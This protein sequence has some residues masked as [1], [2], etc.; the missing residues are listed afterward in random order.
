MSSSFYTV[1]QWISVFCLVVVTSSCSSFNKAKNDA[2][3]TYKP[4][5]AY[6]LDSFN[7]VHPLEENLVILAFSGGGSRAAAL[8]YGVLQELRDTQF[9][10]EKGEAKSLLSD[11][12]IIS[13]VSGGSFTA[14]YYGVFGDQ[15]FTDF[16]DDFLRQSVEGALVA[17]MLNPAY[18]IKS[19]SSGFDRTELAIEYYDKNIFKRKTFADIPLDKRP[20]IVINATDLSLGARFS[21]D[22]DIFD[23]LCSDLSSYPI[24]RAVTASSAVP[25]VFPSVILKNRSGAC[26][27][28]GSQVRSA[29]NSMDRDSQTQT[30]Y[31]A[32]VDA[33]QD[34]EKI[35]YIH[36]VDGG[37]TDNLGLR[38]ISDHFEI[39]G[40]HTEEKSEQSVK[41]I[42]LILVNSAVK[43]TREMDLMSSSPSIS[44][45]LD[46][47]TTTL[48]ESRNSDT[49]GFFFDK[50]SSFEN[51]INALNSDIEF[52]LTEV[53]FESIPSQ[54]T[55]Q[56]FNK[57]PTSLELEDDQIDLL[58]ETGR[59]LLR[60]DP[61][62]NR[63]KQSIGVIHEP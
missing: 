13:A 26:D 14:A 35:K 47:F 49:K 57:L 52:F 27:L 12:D 29:A 53:S 6:R 45:T 8:S 19:L 18:W 21:F 23:L 30:E 63:F 3:T 39:F 46:A 56:L 38:S 20:Y 43:P 24:A 28:S 61:N 32:M 11:V 50:A 40:L 55:R 2:I 51:T 16:E 54:K 62:F 59:K 7:R 31:L 48:I 9:V 42:V 17:N 41:R 10:S 5:N 22:Q 4:S 15:I 60:D 37:L 44:E 34:S 33:Y 1:V 36:L 58:I 25:I